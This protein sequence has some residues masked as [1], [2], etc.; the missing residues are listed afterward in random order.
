VASALEE[1]G[2]QIMVLWEC[3][4][5]GTAELT[6]RLTEFLGSPKW[7]SSNDSLPFPQA[8]F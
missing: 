3:E 6:P 7:D 4:I 8:E 5:G 2:W 1:A